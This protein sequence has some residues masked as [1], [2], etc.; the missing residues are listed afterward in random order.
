MQQVDDVGIG[1]H[2]ILFLH[3]DDG[4]PISEYYQLLKLEFNLH[5]SNATSK[6]Q[7]IRLSGCT[8]AVYTTTT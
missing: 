8:C 7:E 3:K 2:F 4:A 6:P 5:R 1:W